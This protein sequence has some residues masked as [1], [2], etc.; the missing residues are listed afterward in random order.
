MSNAQRRAAQKEL[1]AL[2]RKMGKLQRSVGDVHARMAAHDQS[3]FSGLASLTQEQQGYE[4]ELAEIEE[5][6]L[7]LTDELE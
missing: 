2:E 6:W 7:E 1:S 3:D 4:S 5:R